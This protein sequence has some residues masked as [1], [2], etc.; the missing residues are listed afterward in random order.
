MTSFVVSDSQLLLTE[1]RSIR[2]LLAGK[3]KAVE[4]QTLSHSAATGSATRPTFDS[5]LLVLPLPRLQLETQLIRIRTVLYV[6][7]PFPYKRLDDG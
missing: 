2:A 7:Q 4:K 6:L 3:G 5:H 1:S